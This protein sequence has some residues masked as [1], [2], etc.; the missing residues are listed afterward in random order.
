MITGGDSVTHNS[1]ILEGKVSKGVA[2]EE[3]DGVAV[4]E[5]TGNGEEKRIGPAEGSTTPQFMTN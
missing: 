5:I 3:V 1:L 2:D 4:V